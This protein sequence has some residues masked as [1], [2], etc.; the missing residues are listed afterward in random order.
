MATENKSQLASA[1]P[2]LAKF[3]AFDGRHGSICDASGGDHSVTVCYRTTIRSK[4]KLDGVVDIGGYLISHS[5]SFTVKR[6]D[7]REQLVAFK[8]CI[9][10]E[11]EYPRHSDIQFFA[12]HSG[13]VDGSIPDRPLEFLSCP[14]CVDGCVVNIASFRGGAGFAHEMAAFVEAAMGLKVTKRYRG[15]YDNQAVQDAVD[16]KDSERPTPDFFSTASIRDRIMKDS[17]LFVGTHERSS[18]L[19]FVQYQGG[20]YVLWRDVVRYIGKRRRGSRTRCVCCGNM[21]QPG[22]TNYINGLALCSSECETKTRERLCRIVELKKE[23]NKSTMD[24]HVEALKIANQSRVQIK[25]LLN[26]T[27]AAD[28]LLREELQALET[29]LR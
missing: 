14:I 4:T 29:S 2:M 9:Y 5:D 19:A 6:S 11:F 16:C 24:R 23:L 3:G 26:H 12:I 15:R 7:G 22:L 8:P 28:R 25:K 17:E 21:C 10:D 27:P 13:I 18:P 20:S 1:F